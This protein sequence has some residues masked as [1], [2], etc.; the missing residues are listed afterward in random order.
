MRA[1]ENVSGWEGRVDQNGKA[2]DGSALPRVVTPSS[3]PQ[4]LD[5]NEDNI[6]PRQ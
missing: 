2:M 1:F 5:P 3:Q 4:P 6:R